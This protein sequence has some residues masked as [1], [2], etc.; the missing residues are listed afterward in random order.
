M[1]DNSQFFRDTV[2]RILV[3]TI[4]VND[5]F[6]SVDWR[7]PA[8]LFDALRD[9]CIATMM[10]G[11]SMGGI[12]ANMAEAMTIMRAA[13]AAAAPGPLAKTLLDHA[14]LAMGGVVADGEP[15]SLCFMRDSVDIGA[16]ITAHNVPWA[17]QQAM[18]CG[19]HEHIGR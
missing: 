3:D 19:S 18:S 17:R 2:E 15:L 16:P 10:A 9:N 14:L 8:A 13:G 6:A 5:I 7:M 11:E 1:K 4:S 12:G